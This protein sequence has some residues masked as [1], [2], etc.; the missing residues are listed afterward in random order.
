MIGSL[1]WCS[2]YGALHKEKYMLQCG[3]VNSSTK[4]KMRTFDL[5]Q[6]QFLSLLFIK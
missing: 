4:K 6:Y 5:I 3:K 2:G 1:W